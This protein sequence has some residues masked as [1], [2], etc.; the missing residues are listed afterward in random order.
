MAMPKMAAG[1]KA[2]NSFAGFFLTPRISNERGGMAPCPASEQGG[3][4]IC[5][6]DS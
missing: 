1:I 6:Q 3:G 5:R 4:L 2:E